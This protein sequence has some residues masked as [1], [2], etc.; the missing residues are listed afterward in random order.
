V[1][2][3]G[4]QICI[5][6]AWV[7]FGSNKKDRNRQEIGIWP[8]VTTLVPGRNVRFSIGQVTYA[9]IS[10][11]FSRTCWLRDGFRYLIVDSISE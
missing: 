1:K 3:S 9:K 2:I 6:F 11:T 5:T 7:H 8:I 4:R 10:L